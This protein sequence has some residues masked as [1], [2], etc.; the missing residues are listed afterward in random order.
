MIHRADDSY[1]FDLDDARY[2]H[3]RRLSWLFLVT[4]IIS[5]VVAGLVGLA[6]WQTYQHTLTFY[7]KWQDAL[8]GLSWFLSCIALGGSI[9]I[10]RFLSA[11]HAGNH[12]GMVT[13][14]G[15]ET[16]MVRDLSSENMKSIFWIMNSS[17]W[18]FVA[19]LVGLVPDILL[20]W[21][22]QLPDPLL[23]IFATAIVVL[24]TLAGLVVSIISASFIII[25]ITGGI[26]F[27]RKLGSSHTYKLNGQA[28]IRID[29]FVM[30]IIYPG[31]P[32]SMVDLN[33]LSCEDQKQLLF[34]LRKR[35][36]DAERVWSP[37]LGEEIELALEEA[38]QSIASVA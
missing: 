28:T 13:F 18:C 30:T 14:D 4:L 12:E 7:L 33:L 26:S 8:V 31:N 1:R 11:L 9:L 17:F 35:W 23:V 34:L 16:I 20:G 37:S 22:L 36:M 29:N 32:E 25:G 21:T 38:E 15:K 5:G 24:L 27:G 19:V 6:I 2:S 3:I 10:I